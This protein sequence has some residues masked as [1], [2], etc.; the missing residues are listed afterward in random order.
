[1]QHT[2][3]ATELTELPP[4]VLLVEDD[5]DTREMNSI[6]LESQGIWVAGATSPA[7]A[8]HAVEELKPDV[9]VTDVGFQGQPL[10]L[11]LV[12]SLKRNDTTMDVPVILLSPRSIAWIPEATRAQTA[13]C[14]VAPVLPA[15]LVAHVS[16]VL[17]TSRAVRM[18]NEAAIRRAVSLRDKSNALLAKSREI[19]AR[20]TR[21]TRSCPGCGHR[22]DW[23]E[24]GRIDAR[25]Y[26]YY[27]WCPNRCGL[28]CFD[29]A[30]RD[31]V[32]LV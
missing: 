12:D 18:R 17:S 21:T 3:S 28:Y 15:D 20:V 11:A 22:L 23:I 14:L 1:M 19:D 16:A 27:H 9:I 5:A 13:L 30:A 8:I 24:T 10:G 2:S 29:R 6:F 26:D 25:E 7:E 32:K 4:I 31:W